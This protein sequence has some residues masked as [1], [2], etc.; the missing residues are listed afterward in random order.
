MSEEVKAPEAP[1]PPPPIPTSVIMITKDCAEPLRKCLGSLMQTYLRADD[2]VV[3]VDTGSSDDTVKV[4]KEFG[5]R[6]LE[7]PDLTQNESRKLAEQWLPEQKE[8]LEAPQL[9]NGWLMDFAAARQIGMDAAKHDIVFWIDADDTLEEARPGALRNAVDR[10]FNQPGPRGIFLDYDYQFDPHDGSVTTRLRRERIVD[11]RLFHW[12]GRCHETLLQK[13][14]SVHAVYDYGVGSRIVHQPEGRKDHRISDIRNYV[15]LRKEFEDTYPN[16][17]DPR[18]VFYMGNAARGLKRWKEALGLHRRF[19]RMS[20]SRDDVYNACYYIAMAYIHPEMRRPTTAIDWFW[21][22][23]KYKT[24]DSRG[25]FGLSRCYYLLERYAEALHWFRV[26]AQLPVPQDNTHSYN[27]EDVFVHPLKVAVLS[28]K[29]LGQMELVEGFMNDLYKTRPNHPETV[30]LGN[31][32]RH[33][34]CGEKLTAAVEFVAAN[35][36]DTHDPG[37][38]PELVKG[39]R[40][41]A[42]R[43]KAVPERLERSGI[44][45]VEERSDDRPVVFFCGNTVEPWGPACEGEG[46]GGSEKMTLY[47]SRL[48]TKLGKPCAVYANV[49]DDQRGVDKAGVLWRHFSE[50]DFERPRDTMVFWRSPASVQLPVPAKRRVV[51]CHDVQRPREYTPAVIELADKVVVLSEWQAGTLGAARE[52]L[53]KAGKLVIS[54]NG[55]DP[56]LY[57]TPPAGKRDPLK[58]VFASSPDRGVLSA[59]EIFRRVRALEPKATLEILYGFTPTWF[60]RFANYEY[61]YVPDQACARNAYDYMEEVMDAV[62]NTPGVRWRGRV[63]FA[64]TAEIQ[65]TAGVWLYP[66]RFDEISCMAA[67]EAQAAGCLVVA[68]ERAALA[69]TISKKHPKIILPED[70]SVDVHQIITRTTELREHERQAAAKR[71]IRRFSLEPLAR[72]WAAKIV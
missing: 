30:S 7:R 71:A 17:V 28:A 13:D 38:R 43:L 9:A 72:E 49:P 27:P 54:R 11:R 23:I 3:I 39:M 50:F 19:I 29:E 65:K 68:T 59:I 55:L 61:G 10:I 14:D 12:R 53:E 63:S 6:V 57:Q 36:K 26:G 32:V 40:R 15:I 31:L 21:R 51:W 33:W 44:G 70:L 8:L 67:M 42:T 58:F 1:K 64:E 18:T 60:K 16:N 35:E 41:V 46:I 24:D 2:E 66:T 47:L 52:P 4:A 5:A 56:T 37:L 69:E 45:A 48:I 25:Y 20:G 22:C 34:I 62:D